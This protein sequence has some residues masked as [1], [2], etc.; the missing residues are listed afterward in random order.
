MAAGAGF[1]AGFR[2]R[3]VFSRDRGT[4]RFDPTHRFETSWLVSPWVLFWI[5]AVMSLYCFTTL[6]VIIGYTCADDSLGGCDTV[7]RSFSY[8]TVLTY[9]GLAFYFAVAGA[10][11]LSYA[12]RLRRR[13][14]QEQEQAGVGAGAGAVAGA[15]DEA[16][17]EPSCLLDSLPPPLQTLHSLLY[18]TVVTLPFLVTLVYWIVLYRGP[19][20]A[21][22]FDAWHNVSQ[23]ALNSGFALSEVLLARAAEP[24]WWH[25]PALLAVLLAYLGVAYLTAATQGWYTYRFL[26][27]AAVGGRGI[28]AAYVCGIAAGVVVVFAVV[29]GGIGLRRRMSEGRGRRR[30]RGRDEEEEGGVGGGAVEMDAVGEGRGYDGNGNGGS[31]NK[32]NNNN[33]AAS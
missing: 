7:R 23:H 9:W 15:G 32:N 31:N 24:P 33:K 22:R 4:E 30:R 6:F 11:T 2:A 19:W 27:R 16:G 3:A 12:L 26:D 20:F 1:R 5:R 18:T 28:V 17:D 21:R 29:R 25:L 10:H 13:R 8:F 14:R